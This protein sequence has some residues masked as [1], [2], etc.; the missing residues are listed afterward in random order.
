MTCAICRALAAAVVSRAQGRTGEPGVWYPEI[1]WEVCLLACW[2]EQ[3]FLE[4][5]VKARIGTGLRITPGGSDG[6]AAG[7]V[8]NGQY[9][10]D[11]VGEAGQIHAFSLRLHRLK[12]TL[13]LRRLSWL[14]SEEIHKKR[15]GLKYLRL[16]EMYNPGEDQD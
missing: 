16:L 8:P 1:L 4:H 13:S 5:P 14:S 7:I 2:R 10:G 6:G 15:T 12:P 3:G 9:H 11:W